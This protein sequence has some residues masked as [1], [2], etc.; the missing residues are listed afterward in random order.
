MWFLL[1]PQTIYGGDVAT[2]VFFV[3]LSCFLLKNVFIYTY[4]YGIDC[5]QTFFYRKYTQSNCIFE[6]QLKTASDRCK[7]VPWDYPQIER[8]PICDRFGRECFKTIM[9]N[10]SL[11]NTCDCPLDCETTR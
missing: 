4:F 5:I 10:A 8:M 9:T 11:G 2:V 7:C 1:T 6:C 3:A